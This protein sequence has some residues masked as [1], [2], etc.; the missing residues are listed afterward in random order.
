M[1]LEHD[2]LRRTQSAIASGKTYRNQTSFVID[3]EKNDLARQRMINES[4]QQKNRGCGACGGRRS[5]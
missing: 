5:L 1:Y 4:N 3:Q 2:E